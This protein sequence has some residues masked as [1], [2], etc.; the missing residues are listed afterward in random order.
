MA[1]GSLIFVISDIF[2]MKITVEQA[3]A[4]NFGCLGRMEDL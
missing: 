3:A 1:R 4:T 2:R